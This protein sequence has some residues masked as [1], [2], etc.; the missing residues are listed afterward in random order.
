[1]LTGGEHT[2]TSREIIELLK[3]EGLQPGSEEFARAVD[4]RFVPA[5]EDPT[6][7]HPTIF[8]EKP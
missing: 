8:I 6:A 2:L 7:A 5:H 3:K 1:M 4:E